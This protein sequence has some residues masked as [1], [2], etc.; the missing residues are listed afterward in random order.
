MKGGATSLIPMVQE[1]PRDSKITVESSWTAS[2]YM[3]LY[4]VFLPRR[5]YLPLSVSIAG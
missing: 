3:C 2:T 1:S 5:N 4:G